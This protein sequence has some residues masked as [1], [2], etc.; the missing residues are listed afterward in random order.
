MTYG[1]VY[2][3]LPHQ[4]A[5][6]NAEQVTIESSTAPPTEYPSYE[7]NETKIST[8]VQRAPATDTSSTLLTTDLLSQNFSGTKVTGNLKY[9]KKEVP[10]W[11]VP[12]DVLPHQY[13]VYENDSEAEG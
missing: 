4:A 8:E 11:M 5:S 13:Q 6:S 12:S 3:P 1:L 9:S 10:V 7:P 2:R